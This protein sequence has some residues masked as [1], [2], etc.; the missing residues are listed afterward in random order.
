MQNIALLSCNFM[1]GNGVSLTCE[2]GKRVTVLRLLC[3]RP[4]LRAHDHRLASSPPRRAK[5]RPRHGAHWL[6]ST[7]GRRHHLAAASGGVWVPRHLQTTLALGGA[8]HRVG[9]W[10]TPG[11]AS[12]TPVAASSIPWRLELPAGRPRD[13]AEHE[14]DRL[15]PYDD[16]R[17]ESFRRLSSG[18]R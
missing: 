2:M 8:A 3:L 7:P 5:P 4:R 16:A 11:A 18:T 1:Q 6:G 10:L 9:R 17:A 14:P 12:S 13:P 15:S